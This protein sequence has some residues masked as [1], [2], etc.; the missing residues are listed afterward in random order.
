MFCSLFSLAIGSHA[1]ETPLF[2]DLPSH[3]I[4]Y[5]ELGKLEK[6]LIEK[7]CPEQVG[8]TVEV[9]DVPPSRSR[10]GSDTLV[11]NVMLSTSNA[12]I[13]Y[14]TGVTNKSVISPDVVLSQVNT[15]FYISNRNVSFS[16]LEEVTLSW[17]W[18][19]NSSINSNPNANMD[20]EVFCSDNVEVENSLYKLVANSD[21]SSSSYYNLSFKPSISITAPL[22]ILQRNYRGGINHW[23][24]VNLYNFNMSWTTT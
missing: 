4:S 15:C 20:V 17:N 12:G 6:S 10:S 24:Y 5:D 8:E 14:Y 7:Y 18:F 16:N 13:K 1:E 23:Y 2:N 3:Y 22:V 21:G 11:F 19:A 9:V